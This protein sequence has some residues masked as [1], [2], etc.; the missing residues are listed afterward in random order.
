MIAQA[1][2]SCHAAA[3]LLNTSP[4]VALKARK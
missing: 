2:L 3:A 4:Q 1:D